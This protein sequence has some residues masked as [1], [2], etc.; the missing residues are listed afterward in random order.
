MADARTI[1]FEESFEPKSNTLK[2]DPFEKG[3][4][5]IDSPSLNWL[6]HWHNWL[7]FNPFS[8]LV[9]VTMGWSSQERWKDSWTRSIPLLIWKLDF[10]KHLPLQVQDCQSDPMGSGFCICIDRIIISKTPKDNNVPGIASSYDQTSIQSI[11]LTQIV[12]I[13]DIFHGS[14]M[15]V[16]TKLYF[17]D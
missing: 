14:F 16:A 10:D 17:D 13:L 12:L 3:H 4:D 15:H 6:R 7:V 2:M 9:L 8:Q 1:K 11:T 5:I